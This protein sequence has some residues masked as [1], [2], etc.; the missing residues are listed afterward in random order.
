MTEQDFLDLFRPPNISEKLLKITKDELAAH[1]TVMY[2]L[3]Q[4]LEQLFDLDHQPSR[5]RKIIKTNQDHRWINRDQIIDYYYQILV[6][7]REIYLKNFYHAYFDF[8]NPTKLDWNPDIDLTTNIKVGEKNVEAISYQ[9]NDRSRVII[10]NLFCLELLDQTKITNSVKSHVS[11]WQSLVAL[12]NQFKLEDRFFAPSCIKKCLK[13]KPSKTGPKLNFNVLFYLFQQYQPK[14][15][16]LNPYTISWWLN[17][18]V[19]DDVASAKGEIKMFSPVLSWGSNLL[20]AYFTPGITDYCGIDV[21]PSV[22][23]KCNFLS[24]YCQKVTGRK[25]TTQIIC[26][27]SEQIQAKHPAVV[28]GDYDIGVVCPP[29]FDMEQYPGDNQSTKTFPKYQDWLN[30]Y[31]QPTVELCFKMLKP[32]GTMLVILNDY[33]TLKKQHYHLTKDMITM[34]KGGFELKSQHF[35]INRVSPMRINSKDRT[36]RLY[37]FKRSITDTH[38]ITPAPITNDNPSVPQ[39]ITLRMKNLHVQS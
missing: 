7:G 37:I 3:P 32:N 8:K 19:I 4:T 35:V 5:G 27:P 33:F 28:T 23:D 38:A 16:I 10:R 14:A 9:R 11:F 6:V 21:I 24:E 17:N 18:L 36:E 22:C 15:S 26:C 34:M 20:A 25:I 12:F 30:G 31:W 1:L 13:P 29:Y 2:S 39:K